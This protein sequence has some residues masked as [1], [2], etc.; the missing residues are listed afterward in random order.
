[1]CNIY[2]SRTDKGLNNLDLYGVPADRGECNM[3]G[4]VDTEKDKIIVCSRKKE[5]TTKE[6]KNPKAVS[7][8]LLL[9]NTLCGRFQKPKVSYAK[10]M[11]DSRRRRFI[12][13]S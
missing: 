8:Q 10:R 7:N 6:K 1:M 12:R 5:I 13:L 11:S 3:N 9:L 4:L 2:L